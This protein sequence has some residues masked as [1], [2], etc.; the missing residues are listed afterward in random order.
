VIK[1]TI[2][3][4]KFSKA[5]KLSSLFEEHFAKH[6]NSSSLAEIHHSIPEQS[7]LTA[8]TDQAT[9]FH[10]SIYS[11]FDKSINSP[12]VACYYHL[13]IEWIDL[14]NT[15]DQ[16][17]WAVQRYPSV[18]IHLPHNL[19]V[20][21]F[22]RDNDYNHPLGE[23]NHF[24]SLTGSSKT[25]SL[26]VEQTL[27]WEDY[28]PLELSSGESAILNTS[29]FKH[30]DYINEEGYTRVSLDFRAIPVHVLQSHA[31]PKTTI[32]KAK[33]LDISDYYILDKDVYSLLTPQ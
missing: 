21:E 28:A 3:K 22:H 19:S 31:T 32:S 24:L 17:D 1:Q 25:A 18:R 13:C 2:E 26:F 7:L 30:G 20:F 23:I 12:I 9:A 8:G 10:K 5:A 4:R 14:L 27:G 33:R 16:F 15:I 6:F 11:E 29:I